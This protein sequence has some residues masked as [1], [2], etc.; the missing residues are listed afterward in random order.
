MPSTTSPWQVSDGGGFSIDPSHAD[1]IELDQ[2]AFV[3]PIRW[4]S[5]YYDAIDAETGFYAIY[6]NGRTR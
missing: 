4:K 2:I 5:H 6:M 1:P 3:N